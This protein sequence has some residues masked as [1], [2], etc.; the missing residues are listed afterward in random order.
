[1]EK[2]NN[3]QLELFAQSKDSYQYKSNYS[4]RSFFYNIKKNE[5]LI[6]VIIAFLCTGIVSFI[7]GVERGRKLISASLDPNFGL[8]TNKEPTLEPKTID[9]STELVKVNRN[10]L[11][12]KKES[13]NK[14][15][16]VDNR[17]LIAE[18]EKTRDNRKF[19]IQVASYKG[20]NSAQREAESLKKKGLLATVLPK[21]GYNILCVGSFNNKESAQTLFSQLKKQYPDCRIRRL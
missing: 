17:P 13:L 18:A 15:A 3:S 9:R 7:L 21:S 16:T 10:Q 2:V 1:M 12:A 20:R 8:A 5:K 4:D 19:T 11:L 14:A 6:L